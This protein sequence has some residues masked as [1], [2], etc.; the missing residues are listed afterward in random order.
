MVISGDAKAIAAGAH[1]SM[2]LKQNGSV[3]ATGDNTAGQLG[4]GSTNSKRNFVQ[5]VS[6]G[7]KAI[8]AGG[9]HSMVL[10][11][12]NSVWAT[13]EN[14]YGQLA[15]GSA[16]FKDTFAKLELTSSGVWCMVPSS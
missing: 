1:Y 7:V 12:D 9:W 4:D 2:V 13:G 6:S 15:D 8:A 16:T 10:K 5:V 3:W 11:E 14:T